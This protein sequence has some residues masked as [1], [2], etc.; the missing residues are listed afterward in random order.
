[1]I[2]VIGGFTGEYVSSLLIGHRPDAREHI[3]GECRFA[4]SEILNIWVHH[5]FL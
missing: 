3:D 1:M 5:K 4:L 2:V